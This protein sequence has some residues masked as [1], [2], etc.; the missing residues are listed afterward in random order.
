VA[1]LPLLIFLGEGRPP[2]IAFWP[3]IRNS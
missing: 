2:L 3:L 1:V